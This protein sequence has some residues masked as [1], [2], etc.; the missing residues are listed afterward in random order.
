M[1]DRIECPCDIEFCELLK[2]NPE[3]DI[4]RIY[5]MGS[6]GHHLVGLTA[7]SLGIKTISIT[8]SER[9]HSLYLD[10]LKHDPSIA[11]NYLCYVGNIYTT[12]LE[13]FREL[14]CVNL[15]HLCESGASVQQGM[16][17]AQRAIE[18][19]RSGGFLAFYPYSNAWSSAQE[20]AER[21][22]EENIIS[23]FSA[24]TSRLCLYTKN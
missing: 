9:E 2:N 17:A 11:E 22:L 13:I 18:A 12:P 1:P 21:F 8:F 10:L 5:H 19:L 14:D 15:F 24:P 3:F 23:T 20:I 4:E 16:A 7:H 6:G